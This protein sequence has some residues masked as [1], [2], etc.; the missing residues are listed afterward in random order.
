MGYISV[1]LSTP[2][3]PDA[4]TL[5]AT[6]GLTPGIPSGSQGAGQDAARPKPVVSDYEMRHVIGQGAWGEV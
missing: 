4:T 3:Q 6:G 5:A 1:A 2:A